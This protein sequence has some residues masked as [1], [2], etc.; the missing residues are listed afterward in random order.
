VVG[1]TGVKPEQVMDL[2]SLLG[3]AVDN[4]PGV[5]GVGPKTAAALLNEF[6]SV[7][8]IYARLEA[9]GSERVRE[10]LRGAEA[11]V[12]RNQQMIRLP[13]DMPGLPDVP[14]L[15]AVRPDYRRLL[16]LYRRWGFRGLATEAEQAL[17]GQPELFG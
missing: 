8:G 2:L 3:D 14:Q 1:K 9:V 6:G 10:A 16:E 5:P 4:V 17:N 15:R 12:R 7:D 13:D 11:D